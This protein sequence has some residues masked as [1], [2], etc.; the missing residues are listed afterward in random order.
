MVSNISSSIQ[1]CFDSALSKES[2]YSKTKKE[3]RYGRAKS[4]KD[5]KDKICLFEEDFEQ[6]QF[7]KKQ[8]KMIKKIEDLSEELN[9]KPFLCINIRHKFT[10]NFN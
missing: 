3:E 7:G 2:A 4:L 5:S 8:T 1:D 10:I 9:R 6:L